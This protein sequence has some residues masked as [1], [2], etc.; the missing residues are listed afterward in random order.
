VV[1]ANPEAR[2]RHDEWVVDG[3]EIMRLVIPFDMIAVVIAI[4]LVWFG[5][6]G[7]RTAGPASPDG[8]RQ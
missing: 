2:R 8:T 5:M 7:E 1:R 4:T 3:G 6:R